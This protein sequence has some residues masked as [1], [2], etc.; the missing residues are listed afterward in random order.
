MGGEREG[1]RAALPKARLKGEG[2]RLKQ[3]GKSIISPSTPSAFR[4]SSLLSPVFFILHT[5]SFIFQPPYNIHASAFISSISNKLT[6]T[7]AIG[8]AR[9][10]PSNP[11][12]LAPTSRAKK[13]TTGL[14]FIE[15]CITLGEIRLS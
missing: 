2:E 6:I 5:S 7:P 15:P 12:T 13:I 10:I 4:L 9:K 3:K 11:A 1:F 14:T 8:I